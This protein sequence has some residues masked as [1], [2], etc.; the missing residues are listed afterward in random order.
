M[1]TVQDIEDDF[2]TA[3]NK[4][5]V[6]AAISGKLYKQNMRP[7][8]SKAEDINL[9]VTTLD[10]EQWQSGVVTL[11]AFLNGVT[12]Y[13]SQTVPPKQRISEISTLFAGILEELK[14]LLPNYDGLKFFSAITNDWDVDTKQYFVSC[15]IF[16]NY[17]TI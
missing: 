7:N 16:F 13:K 12:L 14:P 3:V 9:I 11:L 4:T 10:A 5:S 17:L 8:V 2:Y 15:K 1:K 6:V